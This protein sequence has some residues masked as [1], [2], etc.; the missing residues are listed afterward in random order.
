MNAMEVKGQSS[1]GEMGMHLQVQPKDVKVRLE[2]RAKPDEG[3]KDGS[4]AF[5]RRGDK[6]CLESIV[7][8]EM[9]ERVV[10]LRSVVL[11]KKRE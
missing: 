3:V 9:G 7:V 5:W 10:V 11:G 8:D 1:T 6:A 4:H 2:K